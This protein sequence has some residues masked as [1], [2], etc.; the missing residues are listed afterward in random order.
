MNSSEGSWYSPRLLLSLISEL[1]IDSRYV[2]ARRGGDYNEWRMWSSRTFSNQLAA[3]AFNWTQIHA[4]GALDWGKDA[5][6]FEPIRDPS[7]SEEKKAPEE[8]SL[9]DIYRTLSAGGGNR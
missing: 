5:P 4:L 7:H 1:S 3:G 9:L 2:A 8:M 6:K